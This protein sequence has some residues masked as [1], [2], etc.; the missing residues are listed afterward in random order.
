MTPFAFLFV[1]HLIG[2]FLLQ[3]GWMA[4]NKAKQWGPLLAHVAVYTLTVALVAWFGFG[5][6]SLLGIAIVFVS[7]V[8]LD[9]RTLVQWWVK[10]LTPAADA[11]LDWLVIVVD[12]VLHIIILAVV[13][14]V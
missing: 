9:R 10:Q 1:A 12:Q 14:L 2:D 5:G 6:L 13:L 3:T 8:I 11:N 7:H 4:A